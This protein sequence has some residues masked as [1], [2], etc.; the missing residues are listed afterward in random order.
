MHRLTSLAL[1]LPLLLIS[2]PSF[3]Q[4]EPTEPVEA[5]T[6]EA[7]AAPSD[8]VS[9]EAPAETEEAPAVEEPVEEPAAVEEPAP[10]APAAEEPA[11]EEEVPE[12]KPAEEP[13]APS[14]SPLKIGTHTF[15]RFEA[16]ENYDTLG[17]SRTRFQEGDQTVFRS[18][19]TIETNPLQ[20][21]DGVK[22]SL[23]M[24]PQA[25]GAWGTQGIG[26]T[27][28]EANLGIYEGYFKLSSDLITAKVGRFAMNYGDALMVGN[29]DWHQSGRA[30][31][32]AHL[33]LTP[34]AVVVDAFVTQTGE[35]F[36]APSPLFVGDSY[37]WGVYSKLGGAIAEGLDLDAYVLGKS[38]AATD[39]TVTDPT[40][41]TPDT[42]V[43]KD[44]ATHATVGARIKQKLGAIDYRAEAG[45]QFGRAVGP[46]TESLS[47]FAYQADAEVGFTLMPG[48]RIA[49]NGAVASG[50]SDPTDDKNEAWDELYPTTHKWFG[51]MDVIG[52]RTNI[53]S[54]NLKF[55]TKLAESTILKVH[56]HVFSRMED[57]GLGF[58]GT[59]KLAG[60][61]ADTI[62]VQKIG[63]FAY[64]KGMYSVFIPE[65]DHYGTTDLAHYGEIQAGLKF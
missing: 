18:R 46:A 44:G 13:A 33:S 22:G 65:E 48:T 23:Y 3:A 57:N 51:L 8:E 43:H 54:A 35:G 24:A 21:T 49:L 14:L 29:L 27:I 62:L 47:K 7:D 36:N 52:F 28:G 53:M 34:G 2:A 6:P 5:E 30:F 1:T 20:L 50:D 42:Q 38:V 64:T 4:E 9:E 16:R 56:A 61:E 15:S 45:I 25:S 60:Y 10:E 17:V 58:S 12:E 11:E 55:G 31:D 40:G 59:K 39:I 19:I 41:M 32:G 63:K 37:F 26:G